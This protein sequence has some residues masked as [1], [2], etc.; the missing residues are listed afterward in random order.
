MQSARGNRFICIYMHLN[1]L[2]WQEEMDKTIQDYLASLQNEEMTENKKKQYLR[3]T[4]DF[5][6]MAL[7]NIGS[8]VIKL[9]KMMINTVVVPIRN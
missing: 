4:Q 2:R 9:L 6:S 3:W 8:Q 5:V 1:F 7:S